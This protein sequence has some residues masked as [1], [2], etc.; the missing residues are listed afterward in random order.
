MEA[1]LDPAAVEDPLARFPSER[2]SVL[3]EKAAARSG[4]PAI[5]L[6]MPGIPT[7][8]LFDAVGYAMMSS[9]NLLASAERLVRYLRIVAMRRRCDC[10]TLE[11]RVIE[12]LSISLAAAGP[13]RDNESGLTFF[14]LLK[15]FR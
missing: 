12:L 15:F 1:G 6:A 8:S 11:A 10:P 7:P 3:W 4:N 5:G 2:I 9:P 13:S 14:A